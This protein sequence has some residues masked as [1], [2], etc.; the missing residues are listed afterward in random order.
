MFKLL[1]TQIFHGFDYSWCVVCVELQLVCNCT[2]CASTTS[3]QWKKMFADLRTTHQLVT[4]AWLT[5]SVTA[6]VRATASMPCVLSGWFRCVVLSK[7]LHL[8][9]MYACVWIFELK[10][11]CHRTTCESRK[12]FIASDSFQSFTKALCKLF[13]R[14]P[15]EISMKGPRWAPQRPALE[16]FDRS[17]LPMVDAKQMFEATLDGSPPIN[18][19]CA[20]MQ[21]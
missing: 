2:G 9:C 12:I 4:R 16:Q 8:L 14:K 3:L 5:K 13:G 19:K 18:D 10:N 1:P 17:C 7:P 15:H 11:K 20:V 6:F 21:S